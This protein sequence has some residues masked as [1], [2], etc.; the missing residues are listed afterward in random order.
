[1]QQWQNT[2]LGEMLLYDIGIGEI[3]F[4]Y[5]HV[6]RVMVSLYV[7]FVVKYDCYINAEIWGTQERKK[8]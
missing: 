7:L 6:F 8:Y 2:V 1:M 4:G 5:I 3:I